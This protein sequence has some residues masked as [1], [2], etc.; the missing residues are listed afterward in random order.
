MRYSMK[1]WIVSMGRIGAAVLLAVFLCSALV[2]VSSGGELLMQPALLSYAKAEQDGA[3]EASVEA[4]G[5]KIEGIDLWW[6]TGDSTQDNNGAAAPENDEARLYIAT[7]SDAQQLMT[8]QFEI[9]LSGQYDYAPGDIRI[10]FPAQVWHGRRYVTNEAGEMVGEVDPQTLLGGMDLS[11]PAYPSTMADFS[12]QLINGEY[13]LSNTRTIGATSKAMFQVSITGITPHEIVDMSVSE[14]IRVTC[15]VTT[16][17]G[18]VISASSEPL[19]AQLD[20]AEELTHVHKDTN[21]ELYEELPAQLPKELLNNLPEGTSADDYIYVRWYSYI[22]HR[23]NQPFALSVRDALADAYELVE[24]ENGATSARFVTEGIFLGC[25]NADGV[26][27]DDGKYDFAA[28]VEEAVYHKDTA[29]SNDHALIVWSAY[30]KSDFTV[31][32]QTERQRKYYM[33][34]EME[35]TLTEADSRRQTVFSDAARVTYMPMRWKAPQGHFYVHKWTG[36]D[37]YRDRTY[38][39]ALNRLK[40]GEDVQLNFQLE[41]VGF[42]YPWTTRYT[43]PGAVSDHELTQDDMGMMGWRQIITDE[44]TFF[45]IGRDQLTWED[46]EID[47]VRVG[48]PTKLRY[49]KLTRPTYAYVDD[50]GKI[51]SSTMPAGTY[52]YTSDSS[53]PTPDLHLEYQVKGDGQW[54]HAATATWGEDGLGEFGFVDVAEGVTT[55]YTTVYLPENV[56]DVRYSFVSNVYGGKTAERCDLAG[57]YWSVYPTMTLKA[58]PRIQAIAENLFA[59]S[60]TPS[61]KFK[62]DVNMTVDGWVEPD[63]QGTE[64]DFKVI[65]SSR[66]TLDGASW[67]VTMEK[68]VKFNPLSTDNHGDNDV[69]RR[70][71]TL[72]Y[73]AKVYEQSNLGVYRDYIDA[74]NAGVIPAETKGVWY[75][76]LPPG[77]YPVLDSVKLRSGDTITGMYTV[78]DYKGSGRILLVVEADLAPRPIL[79]EKGYADVPEISFDAVYTW[80]DLETLGSHLTNYV[81]FES[82]TENLQFDTL[83]TIA[84]ERGEPDDPL[85]GFNASTP[86]MDEDTALWLK[87]LDP[88]TDENRFVYAKADLNVDINT[89]AVSGISKMV[90]NAL[91]GVY[92]QGLKDQHQ[93]SVF[94]GQRYVYRL[95]VVSSQNTVTKDIVIYDTVENYQ[96]PDP[97]V[98]ATKAGEYADQQS[99]INW[100]GDW[101]GKGQW[102]GT[103]DKVDLGE[104]VRD[105]AAPVLYYSL[106]PELTFADSSADET[107]DGSLALFSQGAYDLTDRSVWHEAQLTEDG[108]WTVPESIRGQVSAVAIDARSAEE[109]GVYTLDEGESVAAYLHMTAPD[110]QGDETVWNAKGAYAH[111]K[112][113]DGSPL[114]EIDW[115]RALDPVNNM[116]AYNNTRLKCVQSGVDGASDSSN[117]MIRNDYTRVGIKPGVLQVSKVWEDQNNHDG[118]RPSQVTVTLLRKTAG[119]AGGYQAVQGADGQPCTVTL[120]EEN[121]WTAMFTQVDMAD[122]NG[123]R[124]IYSFAENEVPGYTMEIRTLSDNSFQLVNTHQNEVTA[125]TGEKVWEDDDNALN[126][127]PERITVRL[128]RDGEQIRRITVYPDAQGQW[129]YSFGSLEKYEEGGREYVYTV[130]EDYVPKYVSRREGFLKLINSYEPFG[131]LSVSK[132]VLNATAVTQDKTFSYTL[133]LEAEK[134]ADQETAVPLMDAYAYEIFQLAQ[135]GESWSVVDEGEISCGGSF[136]LKADQKMVIYDLPSESTYYIEED[137]LPGFAMEKESG[138]SGVIRAGQTA[139]AE[140]VNRYSTRGY[141]QLA[142]TKQMEGQAMSRSQFCFEVVDRTDPTSESYGRV[143][144]TAYNGTAQYDQEALGQPISS[145]AEAWFGQLTYTGA[146]H[147]RIFRYEVREDD[148]G[149]DGYTYDD[150]VYT[151][152]VSVEDNGDGTMAVQVT[153][154]NGA[155]IN[156]AETLTFSNSYEATGEVNLRAWKD[157]LRRDLQPGEFRFAMYLFDFEKL[158]IVGEPL[159]YAVNDAEGNV[160]FPALAFNQDCV[161]ADPEKPAVYD[162]II[163]EVD[164]GDAT[165]EYSEEVYVYRITVYDNR[166]GTLGFSQKMYRADMKAP[167]ANVRNGDTGE[168]LLAGRLAPWSGAPVFTNEVKDGRLSV[169]KTILNAGDVANQPFTF[170]VRLYGEYV[171]DELTYSLGKTEPEYVNPPKSDSTGTPKPVDTSAHFHASPEQLEGKAYAVLEGDTLTFFRSG[172]EMLDYKGRAFTLNGGDSYEM[173]GLVYFFVDEETTEPADRTWSLYN[174]EHNTIRKMK[175]VDAIRPASGYGFFAGVYPS[176]RISVSGLELMDSSRM[177]DMRGMFALTEALSGIEAVDTSS[178]VY[179]TSMFVGSTVPSLNLTTFDTSNVTDMAYMFAESN[180]KSL[181]VSS[182]DTSRVETMEGMFSMTGFE[183]LDLSSF[184]TSNVFMMAGMFAESRKLMKLDISGFTTESLEYC[185]GMFYN[186]MSLPAVDLSGFGRTNISSMAFMFS[187]CEAMTQIDMP[188]F[189]T[190]NLTVLES[191]FDGCSSLVRVNLPKFDTSGVTSMKALFKGCSSL[192]SVDLSQYDTSSVTDISEMLSGCIS[193]KTVDLSV[194]DTSKVTELS[195]LLNGCSGLTSVNLTGIDVSNVRYFDRMFADCHRLTEIDVSGFVTNDVAS[196]VSMFENC[197][198]LREMDL[199]HFDARHCGMTAGLFKNCYSL[200]KA[201]ISC[202][203]CNNDFYHNGSLDHT[204]NLT[205]VIM[206]KSTKLGHYVEDHPDVMWQ[207]E[208]TGKT[209]TG[210]ELFFMMR[211]GTDYSGT[212]TRRVPTYSIAFDFN[213]GVGSMGDKAT[214]SVTTP[215]VLNT[216]LV[217]KDY[218]LSGFTDEDGVFYPVADGLLM[219]PANVRSENGK[220]TL[221][222]QWIREK[223]TVELQNGEFTFTLYGGQ[224]ATFDNL[225]AGTVYEVWEDTPDGWQLTEMTNTSGVIAPVT[226]SKASFTNEYNQYSVTMT[227]EARK[228]LDGELAEEGE[229]AFIVEGEDIDEGYRLNEAA[230]VVRSEMLY[231]ST[232]DKDK[233]FTYTIYETEGMYGVDPSIIYDT[234]VYTAVVSVWEDEEGMLRADIV[235]KDAQG[236]ELDGLPVFRNTT[237]PGALKV[238][239]Q[240]SGATPE[241]AKQAFTFEATFTDQYGEPWSGVNGLVETDGGTLPVEDGKVTVSLKGGESLT[242]MNLPAGLNYSVKE[243]GTYPGWTTDC[244]E[245]TGIVRTMTT[246]EAGFS[247]SYSAEGSATLEVVKELVGRTPAE[248]EFTFAL[249][250]GDSTAADRLLQTAANSRTRVQTNPDAPAGED[251]AYV[252][253]DMARFDELV[254]TEEGVYRYTI[255]EVPGNDPTV[256]YAGMTIG[257]TVTVADKAGNGRLDVDVAYEGGNNTII[258]TVKPGCLKLSKTV[259][260]GSALHEGKAFTFTLTLTDAQDQ[261]LNGSYPI[262]EGGSLNVTDG[263][264]TITLK[265]GETAT[266]ERLPDG[267]KYAVAEA[268][269]PGFTQS[270]T[271]AQGVIRADE[272]AEADF[273]NTYHAQG[274][275]RLQGVKLL[276]GAELAAGQFTFE[277]LDGE[278]LPIAEVTNAADGSI[279]FAEWF[280]DEGDAGTEKYMLREI[281]GGA[282]GYTYDERVYEITLTITDNGEGV[283][284]VQAEGIPEGGIV[285]QNAYSKTCDVTATKVWQ[286]DEEHTGLRRDIEISLYASAGGEKTLV[287]SKTIAADAQGDHLTVA[288]T[289]LPVFD[290]A[291]GAAISYSVEE[292][293]QLEEGEG[294]SYTSVITGNASEGFIIVNRYAAAQ[295]AVEARKTLTGG[296][297]A[298]GQFL[299]RLTDEQGATAAEARNAA[300]GTIVFPLLA[301][302]PGDLAGVKAD[303]NGLRT[304]VMTYQLAEVDEGISGVTYDETVYTVEVTLTMDASGS[305]EATVRTLNA[306][307]EETEAEFANSIESAVFTVTKSWQGGGGG[308]IEL[309]LYANGSKL[310][311]QPD[312]ERDGDVY[313]YTGL[314][315]YDVQGDLIVY[316][317]KERYVTGFVTIYDNVSPYEDETRMIYDGGTIINRAEKKPSLTVTKV[318][319]GLEDGEKKPEITLT[320]YCNGVKTDVKTPRPDSQGR[321][322]YYDLPAMVNNQPAVYT[323]VEEPL[324]D[325]VTTYVTSDGRTV[326]CAMNGDVIVNTKLPSTGDGFNPVLWLGLMTL[327]G[328][329]LILC[330]RKR[331]W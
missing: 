38:G 321:Y 180:I 41:A 202:F 45:D 1:K 254:Y 228:L 197:Y 196:V 288:W 225:P 209:L 150:T 185:E 238:S 17:Q 55:Q 35:W 324:R 42:G 240:I 53:L 105:G 261:P 223:Q 100:Q 224:T 207:N 190:P 279:S 75:D 206:G 72:H 176:T 177:E 289:E 25:T 165:V 123:N 273:V 198:S 119:V 57:V 290:E 79:K 73:S 179:M 139:E 134:T 220:L 122:E 151:V 114:A 167:A 23:G 159:A 233:T 81:A 110:D 48:V 187:G 323:V 39:Y 299:F 108:V 286:G 234:S 85:A 26:L 307:G 282:D 182:F 330:R 188:N 246:E 83:G 318:W 295:A 276:D 329:L 88:D 285:F 77:V 175:L 158:E 59:V 76:L 131:N 168:N 292:T 328:A 173:D 201:D 9:S 27:L 148:E 217:R 253:V 36:R 195:G 274:S 208:E 171:T 94:E 268:E 142:A 58:S 241:A 215:V 239:K 146:D 16:R 124:Y 219:V 227:I 210:R 37:P 155:P 32:G 214:G 191:M 267:V 259:E 97:S 262:D 243:V 8:Y 92:S 15:E 157:L 296:Q 166:D 161:S 68:S 331:V 277:L 103:L 126:T 200:E 266:I 147:G 271:G 320:L 263:T 96:L 145:S 162:Y 213:G 135:D 172:E 14:P 128:L 106:Q 252:W 74:R 310:S 99:K 245:V 56:T 272:T 315:K 33:Q 169:H 313:M 141:A 160:V 2:M 44:V 251:P 301:Y 221:T 91:E 154:E 244:S 327:S 69:A 116:Y 257:V 54:R 52:A 194:M 4:D 43:M 86:R 204:G 20:T 193:L 170:H 232:W 156:S 61:T 237:R 235:Y 269:A 109:G 12:W 153:D 89:A 218:V 101:Q 163:M 34:N 144:S 186:C 95:R 136:Q 129:S 6:V 278:G 49:G 294:S 60:D 47:A 70:L 203:P 149:K 13:V 66:A 236:N 231:F 127:R 71:V 305:M 10:T 21:N 28:V 121:G 199:H 31:P 117:M 107:Q 222:A 325:Y 192:T 164:T 132:K 80:A 230:G 111:K 265:H 178:A 211:T 226:T 152:L 311:P 229:F 24:D 183:A 98:D 258:N 184:D 113:E 314:P 112:A 125:L 312:W 189:E 284:E 65:E 174:I 248:G 64:L 84:G 260:G 306:D 264:A 212:W 303:E 319:R 302:A 87:D 181:D 3:A 11:V 5:T 143:V 67:G 29:Q 130:E 250:E 216:D 30:K 19:T 242:L 287:G 46:F 90:M 256:N 93:V 104:F 115:L 275:Y 18:T 102:R 249:Y 281:N 82:L 255:R 298:A 133:T 322:K 300:D 205:E 137:P 293:M 138:S 63:G 22:Y 51:K 140:F 118:L 270:S 308:A 291:T 317:A 78:P 120:N 326:E 309:I 247:N 297:L 40:D 304:R 280:Y 316:S 283:M 62:N 50:G 7:R